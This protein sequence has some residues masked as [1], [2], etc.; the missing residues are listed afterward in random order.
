LLAKYLV[1]GETKVRWE[2]KQEGE[3]KGVKTG[4]AVEEVD[5]VGGFELLWPAG[6]YGRAAPASPK[7][8]GEYMT[9]TIHCR[10]TAHQRV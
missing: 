6:V 1:E 8:R 7:T 5:A 4:R 9:L 10:H 3:K 2:S